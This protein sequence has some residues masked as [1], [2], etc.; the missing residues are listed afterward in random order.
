[1]PIESHIERGTGC[2]ASSEQECSFATE[3]NGI[4]GGMISQGELSFPANLPESIKNINALEEKGRIFQINAMC[5]VC[6]ALG[7]CTNNPQLRN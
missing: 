3:F 5:R 6:G 4:V 2:T 1:M 7:V